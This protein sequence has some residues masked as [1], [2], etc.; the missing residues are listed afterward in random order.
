MKFNGLEIDKI[1]FNGL[2]VTSVMIDGVDL[3][4]AKI[5]GVSWDK[6]ENPVLT[7]TDDAID[8]VANAGI[9]N[10]VVVNDFDSAEIYKGH[11]RCYRF[12]R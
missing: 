9:D 1:M 5:Y 11:Y 3:H 8:M 6:S 2:P 10:Q 7:R 12:L 4:K